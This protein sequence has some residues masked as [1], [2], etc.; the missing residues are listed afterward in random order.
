MQLDPPKLSLAGWAGIAL[1]PFAQRPARH[2]LLLID[3]LEQ[4]AS[5]EI[6]RLMVLM[7]PGSAKSTYASKVF[8]A[9]WLYRHPMSAIIAASHTAEL[10]KR[11]G[12][13]V[14]NLIAENQATLGYRLAADNHAAWRFETSQRGEYFAAGLG[15]PITGHRA[16]LVVIDDPVK[17]RAEADSSLQRE[18]I[19]EWYRSDLIGRLKPGGRIVLVM[20][21]WHQDDLGG[22]LLASGDNWHTLVLPALAGDN[23]ELGRAPGEPLWPEWESLAELQRKRD[24]VGPRVWQAQYQQDPRP[25]AEALFNTT[26]IGAVEAAPAGLT[27]VRAWDLAATSAAEGRDPDWTVGLKLGRHADGRCTVLDVIRLRGGPHEVA[28]AVVNTAARD[29]RTVRVG[30]PQDPGQ[31]GKQQVAWLIGKLPGHEVETST[32]TGSKLVR[33]TPVAAQVNAGNLAVVQADWNLAF[34]EELRDFPSGRKDDQ[35]DALARAFSMLTTVTAKPAHR[36]N[37]SV[38]A[39]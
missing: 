25:N 13:Q 30:I 15:G 35:V 19:W 9:W 16:D 29:G 17:N 18:Q 7:P 1:E 14:R 3:K 11:F 12:R 34:V 26:R 38:M 20:T 22:R 31:A 10:A 24:N 2:H 23:D 28:D 37:L 27:A 36:V 39:R 21:R 32:E 6:D 8:P 5:G 4:V 33:A